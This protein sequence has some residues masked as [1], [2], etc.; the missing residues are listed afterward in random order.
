LYKNVG[1]GRVAP[2]EN[3]LALC[4]LAEPERRALEH[5]QQTPGTRRVQGERVGGGP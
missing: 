1:T 3:E 2:V 4:R 5:G